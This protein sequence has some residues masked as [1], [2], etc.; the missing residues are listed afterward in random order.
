[1]ACHH[2]GGIGGAGLSGSNVDLLS[3]VFSGEKR[4]A[5]QESLVERRAHELHP[6][7]FS[8]SARASSTV[9]HRF[10]TQPGYE[11]WRAAIQG[12]KLPNGL[13]SH[14]KAVT[15]RALRRKQSSRQAVTELPRKNGVPLHLSQRNTPTLFGTGAIDSL[16]EKTLLEV[17]ARQA[18]QFP[19]IQGRLPRTAAGQLGRFG[20]RGQVPTLHEFV[21]SACAAELGLQNRGHPQAIDPLNPQQ[22]KLE[23]NDLSP[24]QCDALIAFVRSLPPPQQALPGSVEQANRLSHGERLFESVGCAGCHPRDLGTIQGIFSDQLLHDMGPGLEDPVAAFPERVKVG[25]VEVSGA[26]GGSGTVD[27]FADLETPIRREWKT[28]P[29]WGVRDS[30]PYLHDGR[31]ATLV[32]AIAAHGGQADQSRRRFEDLGDSEKSAVLAFLESL[33]SSEPQVR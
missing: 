16:S 31:A 21:L 10:D 20:W 11:A 32:E 8:P 33:V 9:F 24:E 14:Q 27:Q 30:S 4:T 17:A 2:L 15:L 19:G 28:P 6:A 18:Q 26:Y 22:N 29:L 1:V 7:L 23:G 3:V 25:T 13:K 12:F 5:S